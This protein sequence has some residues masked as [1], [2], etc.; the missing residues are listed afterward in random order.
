MSR[1]YTSPARNAGLRQNNRYQREPQQQYGSF[2]QTWD[3]QPMTNNKSTWGPSPPQ[4]QQQQ[5]Q[6]L[7]NDNMDESGN[8]VPICECGIPGCV[9]VR[10]SQKPSNPNRPFFVCTNCNGFMWKDKWNGSTELKKG[11]ARKQPSNEDKASVT[12]TNILAALSQISD[13]M[14]AHDSGIRC[15]H[16]TV[17]EMLEMLTELMDRVPYAHNTHGRLD[18]EVMQCNSNTSK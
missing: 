1:T 16:E 4:Q 3:K 8:E 14:N 13:N 18:D 11:T 7:G 10:I 17:K 5:Q 6:V 9:V 12:E 15:L 2:Q